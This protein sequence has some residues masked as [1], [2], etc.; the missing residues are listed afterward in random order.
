MRGKFNAWKKKYISQHGKFNVKY[1]FG[2]LQKVWAPM[3][4][5]FFFYLALYHFGSL[6]YV[7]YLSSFKPKK[8]QDALQ[9]FPF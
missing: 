8:S 7:Y 6:T 2:G 9:I 1:C 4:L 5:I 3:F